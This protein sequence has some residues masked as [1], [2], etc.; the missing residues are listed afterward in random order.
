MDAVNL[1]ERVAS[2]GLAITVDGDALKIRGR[3]TPEAE[4]LLEELRQ[5]KQ[6]ILVLLRR[7]AEL[8]SPP[9]YAAAACVCLVPV[10][11][12]GS[13]RFAVCELP[14]ICPEC[15]RCRGCKLRLKFPP[16]HGPYG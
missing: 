8:A 9:D 4:A 16:G 6:E 13:A 5:Q 14:L 7:S 12:T 2:L 3:R 10:G 1:L 11:G 15:G